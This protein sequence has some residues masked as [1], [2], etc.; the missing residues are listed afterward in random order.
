MTVPDLTPDQQMQQLRPK[1]PV[2]PRVVRW[3]VAF[4]IIIPLI[5]AVNGLEIS[6]ARIW[7]APA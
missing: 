6:P 3:V 4:A 2:G 1:E 5:W 7:R